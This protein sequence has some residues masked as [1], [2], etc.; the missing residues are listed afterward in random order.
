MKYFTLTT[1]VLK[2]AIAFLL[3]LLWSNLAAQ[4]PDY[5]NYE[6]VGTD[7]N[8]FPLNVSTGK[9]V[10]WLFLS[11]D[12]NQPTPLP[13]GCELVNV[14]FYI[15]QGG[16]GSFNNFVIM[17]AQD[18]ITSLT[19]GSLYSGTMDTVYYS[20]TVTLTATTLTWMKIVLN[21]AYPYDPNKSL[22]VRIGQCG[23]GTNSLLKVRQNALTAVRRTWSV[24]GCPFVPFSGGNANIVNFGIDVAVVPVELTS[25]TGTVNNNEVVLNWATATETNNSGFEVERKENNSYEVVGFVY[26]QGT[27]TEVS[28]YSFVDAKVEPGTYF[29]RLKQIDLD[30]TY[31]YSNEVEVNV[32]TPSKFALDQN[33]P[34]PFNP[35]TLIKYS[36]AVDSKVSMKVF[37]VIGQEVAELL[38]G[39]FAAG[40]HEVH[41]DASSLNS[42]VYFYRINASG[43]NGKSYSSVKKM[44]LTK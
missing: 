32:S 10:E 5:Y 12:F 7:I 6:N 29:Y 26:G 27:T 13:S 40:G 24:G 25:F 16:S 14:Y 31:E 1:R 34:N 39:S 35:T 17:M 9:A 18:T 33:Y 20:Q 23:S 15:G 42:G 21:S 41:F 2:N 3:L 19:S 44:I 37:N 38:N 11:G 43:I 4:T 30:G 22:I 36:L 8:S 28:N